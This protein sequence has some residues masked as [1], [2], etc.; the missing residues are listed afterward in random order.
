MARRDIVTYPDPRLKTVC[1]PVSVID[2]AAR[3]V[4][5]DLV[6]TLEAV[7]GTGIAAPQIGELTRI[8]YIDAGRN[9][10]YA[11]ESLGPLLLINPVIVEASGSKRFREGCLSLPEF[12]GQTRR[13]KRVVV[14]A[15]DLDGRARRIEAQDFQAVLLQHEIDHLDGVLFPERLENRASLLRRVPEAD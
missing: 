10:K 1:A 12:L 6:E 2:A 8:I 4:A 14:E 15:L 5:Q 7:I 9:P 13:A 3:A 11:A